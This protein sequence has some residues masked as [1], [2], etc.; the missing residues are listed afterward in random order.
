[1]NNISRAATSVQKRIVGTLFLAQS[2]FSASTIAVFTLTP[3]ISSTLSGSDSWAGL[4]NTIVLL[5]R[6]GSAIPFAYLMDRLGRRWALSGGYS[7]AIVGSIISAWSIVEGSYLLF[8]IGSLFIGFARSAGDQSRYVGAEVFQMS[9]RAKI[10]GIIVFAGTIGAILGPLLVPASVSWVAMVNLPE[11]IGPFL[12]SAILMLLASIA[13]FFF[14]RP[15]PKNLGEQ[16]EEQER[17]EAGSEIQTV[18]DG[19]P[20]R[21]IFSAPL[22]QLAVLSMVISFFVMAFLMV[23]TPLHMDRASHTTGAIST[24]IMAHT[25]G[26]FGLSWLTGWLIDRVGRIVMILVGTGIL[27]IACVL[28]PLSL[29]VPILG[30][31]LFLLGLGWNF[32]FVAGSSLLSDSLA[33]HERARG[34]G[35]SE[36]IVA[37]AAGLASLS[38]GVVFAWG[39]FQ[40]V[41][42][43]AFIFTFLLAAATYWLTRKDNPVESA[44]SID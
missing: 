12:A 25:M 29:R 27:G 8:L 35:A 20:L 33:A 3:I 31:A 10:I 7:M 21:L 43:I 41:S 14:L 38:V 18:D 6:A 19:R 40:L 23:I 44:L 4:P 42:I 9:R 39:G 32:C 13:V 15:D 11:E 36:A 34:Q 22:V 30:L 1:M 37:L 16:I 2:L 28:A 5:G 26:M 17:Q 24:V